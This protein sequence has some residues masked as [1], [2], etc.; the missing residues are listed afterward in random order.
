MKKLIFCIP[1]ILVRLPHPHPDLDPHP[2]PLVRGTEP[3]IRIRIRTVPNFPILPPNI[4]AFIS[5]KT[6]C[7]RTVNFELMS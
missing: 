3:R 6:G 4:V 5:F 1:K 2:N 7:N